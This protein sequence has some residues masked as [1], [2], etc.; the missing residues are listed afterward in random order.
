VL[1]GTSLLLA[2]AV[3][4]AIPIAF[5]TS[6]IGWF[7]ERIQGVGTR[8]GGD[9]DQSAGM[10]QNPPDSGQVWLSACCSA[11]PRSTIAN[12]RITR[13]KLTMIGMNFLSFLILLVISLAV[14]A[15]LHYGLKYYVTPGIWSFFA[16]VTVGWVGAWLGSP[17]LGH[18]PHGI[19]YQSVY[20]IPAIL[21][22]LGSLVVAVD[23]V[24][25]TRTSQ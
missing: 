23:L 24:R 11:H 4:R 14:S 21:G 6:I 7:F 8:L 20:V 15:V 9:Y 13:G 17:V 3:G 22:A 10:G 18:W 2:F 19:Q 25:M 1:I 12:T 5:G 16:K